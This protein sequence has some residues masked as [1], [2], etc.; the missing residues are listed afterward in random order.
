MGN[1]SANNENDK[2]DYEKFGLY[3]PSR[4]IFK[5]LAA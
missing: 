2:V 3:G 5:M 4:A 1:D